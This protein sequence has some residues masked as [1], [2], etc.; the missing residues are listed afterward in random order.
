[1]NPKNKTNTS[2]ILISFFLI[3][4]IAAITLSRPYF[5]RNDATVTAPAM[6]EADKNVSPKSDPAQ[7][8]SEELLEKITSGEKMLI[9]DLRDKS[10]FNQ[11]HIIDSKNVTLR[12]ITSDNPLTDKN[13]PYILIDNGTQENLVLARDAMLKKGATTVLYLKD[14]FQDWKEKNNPTISA[15]NPDSFVD[16]SKVKHIRSEELNSF[17]DSEKNLLIIDLRSSENYKTEH[18]KG[19]INIPLSELETRRRELP[20][21]KNIVLYDKDGLWAFQG[22]VRFFD[23]GFFNVLYLSDGLDTWKAKGYPLEK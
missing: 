6:N 9:L 1:M 5:D 13:I 4:I 11:E 15:G 3:A 16:K 23:L 21:G 17:A 2:A 12:E 14:S 19:A 7:I 8:S 20:I 22:A 10:D 18:I